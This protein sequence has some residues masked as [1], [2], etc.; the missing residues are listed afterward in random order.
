VGLCSKSKE[1][2]MSIKKLFL[3]VMLISIEGCGYRSMGTYQANY[4]ETLL[5]E[6]KD[7][8][9]LYMVD[10]SSVT[11]KYQKYS[12]QNFPKGEYY[13]HLKTLHT[14]SN[15]ES[16]NKKYHMVK[17]KST[18]FYFTGKYKTIEPFLIFGTF[19]N[20]SIA[21]QIH[22]GGVNTWISEYDLDSETLKKSSW[23]TL[24]KISGNTNVKES[25]FLE[26][27]D[28]LTQDSY[29]EHWKVE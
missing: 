8:I 5:F 16:L 14:W 22:I 24:S 4:P 27:L 17:V 29:I 25:L 18:P 9:E 3:L 21:F 1:E 26:N 19:V 7:E 20:S 11:S 10:D 23:I 12:R 28:Y 2:Q 6:F 15:F 13:L